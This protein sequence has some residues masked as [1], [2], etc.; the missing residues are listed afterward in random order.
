MVGRA[1]PI[2]DVLQKGKTNEVITTAELTAVGS[3]EEASR[4]HLLFEARFET[5]P[6]VRLTYFCRIVNPR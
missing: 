2:G 1:D 3:M 5:Q 4:D 6:K